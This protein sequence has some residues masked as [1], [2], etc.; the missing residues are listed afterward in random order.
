M[1]FCEYAEI[2]KVAQGTALICQVCGTRLAL[3]RELAKTI[4][5]QPV[6]AT[7]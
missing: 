7:R 2:I 6:A 3:S 5:I 4:L 1:G